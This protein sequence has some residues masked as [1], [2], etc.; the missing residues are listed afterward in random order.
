MPRAEPDRAAVRA[1]PGRARRRAHRASAF[2]RAT[3]CGACR[4]SAARR[5]PISHAL[6]ALRADAS[7]RQRRR[8]PAR[9]RRRGARVRAARDRHASDRRRE[10]NPRLLRAVRRDLRPRATRRARSTRELEARPGRARRDGVAALPRERVL[11]LIWRKPW[12]TVARDTYVSRDAGPRRLRHAAR[13]DAIVAIRRSTTTTRRGATPTA[14]CCRPSRTRFASAM[15]AALARSARD[16]PRRPD[17]RRVDVVV[18]RAR[19]RRAARALARVSRRV[20]PETKRRVRLKAPARATLQRD[21]H[22]DRDAVRV[23]VVLAGRRRSHHVTGDAARASSLA[24]VHARAEVEQRPSCR[25]ACPA[26]YA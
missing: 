11:Y 8:E 7:R 15:R 20:M 3:T 23:A 1:G 13:G 9:G 21:A 19:D 16:K 6:R 12:M 24:E 10:D 18:R 17:R 25:R 4:R 2:I 5:I 14:S 26:S 22:A